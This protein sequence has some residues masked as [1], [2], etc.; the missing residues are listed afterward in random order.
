[1]L[2]RTYFFPLKLRNQ[3]KSTTYLLCHKTST[4]NVFY[5]CV[6]D[7][8]L[9]NSAGFELLYLVLKL[10]A[11]PSQVSSEIYSFFC[12]IL[13]DIGLRSQ[14]CDQQNT[15]PNLQYESS[16]KWCNLETYLLR[17]GVTWVCI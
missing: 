12:Q 17:Y 9:L 3:V 11:Y 6:D 16:E 2:L 14:N 1:M 13:D 5:C 15:R 4:G 10:E 8:Q 7:A